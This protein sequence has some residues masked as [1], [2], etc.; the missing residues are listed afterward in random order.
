MYL[1]LQQS[2]LV[3]VFFAFKLTDI[4]PSWMLDIQKLQEYLQVL[5]SPLGPS[6]ILKPNF[7]AILKDAL[8]KMWSR[9]Y[10]MITTEEALR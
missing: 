3:S 4:I 6:W 2:V 10:K 5:K 9:D 8:K 1:L 7:V